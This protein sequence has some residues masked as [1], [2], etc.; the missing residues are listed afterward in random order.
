M[1]KLVNQEAVTAITDTAGD[2]VGIIYRTNGGQH[3]LYSCKE[4]NER[5]IGELIEPVVLVDEHGVPV[6]T[7]C[8]RCG[9]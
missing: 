3:L 6:P 9:I 2:L 8:V 5:E 4:M 1:K 7:A